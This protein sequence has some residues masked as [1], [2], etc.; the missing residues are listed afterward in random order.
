MTRLNLE[1]GG[2]N[3]YHNIKMCVSNIQ[4]SYQV[5]SISTKFENY[6]RR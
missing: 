6:Y 4:D 3:S 5:A 2:E 1:G